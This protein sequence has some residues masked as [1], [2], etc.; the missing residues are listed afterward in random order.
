MNELSR[1]RD[2]ARIAQQLWGEARRDWDEVAGALGPLGTGRLLALGDALD[3]LHA[4][5][6]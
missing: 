6:A 4:D 2:V 3:G 1:L 5:A